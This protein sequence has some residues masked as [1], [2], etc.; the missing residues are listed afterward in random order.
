MAVT[1][2]QIDQLLGRI[3][4]LHGELS[5]VRRQALA[6]EEAY[7]VAKRDYELKLGGV[8][9]EAARLEGLRDSLAAR[10]RGV[11]QPLPPR[12]EPPVVQPPPVFIGDTQPAK[13]VP[14]VPVKNPRTERK[15]VLLDYLYYFTDD[16]QMAH[17]TRFNA[18]LDDDQHDVGDLL[19]ALEWGDIWRARYEWESLDAQHAR[20]EGWRVALVAQLTHWKERLSRQS[21]GQFSALRERREKLTP[22]QW[23]AFLDNLAEVQREQNRTLA[24]KVTE[25][26]QRWRA[27]EG[28][29]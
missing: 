14:P 19:E 13:I 16:A 12:P 6:L 10:L 9:A 29:R 20:L 15:R 3:E 8:N 26:E 23:A 18:V 7:D 11:S 5:I 4:V 21:E 22:E 27:R 2:V 1:Q 25:L 28:T 17:I 24:E